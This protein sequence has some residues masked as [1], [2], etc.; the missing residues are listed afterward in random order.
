MAQMAIR[1]AN[2]VVRAAMIPIADHTGGKHQQ[3]DKRQRYPENSNRLLHSLLGQSSP[4][5][6]EPHAVN[7]IL[8]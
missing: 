7:T 3:R 2:V 8:M 1:A 5:W 4:G 6:H